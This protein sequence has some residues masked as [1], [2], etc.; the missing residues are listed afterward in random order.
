MTYAIYE[1]GPNVANFIG[2]FYDIWDS[3]SATGRVALL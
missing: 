2:E 3:I 1:S